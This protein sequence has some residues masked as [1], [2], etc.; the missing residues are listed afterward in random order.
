MAEPVLSKHGFDISGWV[1]ACC[2]FK[3]IVEQRVDLKEKAEFAAFVYL[4][5]VLH[6]QGIRLQGRHADVL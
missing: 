5:A 1:N 3:S 2:I 4:A 6:S